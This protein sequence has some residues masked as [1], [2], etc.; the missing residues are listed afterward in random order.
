MDADSNPNMAPAL[1]VTST[2]RRL[3]LPTTLVSRRR[4]GSALT[5]T[6][7]DILDLHAAVAPDDVRLVHMGSP[8]HAEEGC[9]CS[10]HATVAALLRDA[11]DREDLFTVVD[12]EA[13]PEH[14]SRGTARSVDLLLLVTEPYYR[15]LES[16]R[17]LGDLAA[18]L[19]IPSVKVLVNKVRSPADADAVGEFCD[20]HGLERIAEVPWSEEAIN[21][22]RQGQPLLDAAPDSAAVA[23]VA[24]LADSLAAG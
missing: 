22:D 10:A 11:G 6:V 13:S 16:A 3:G 8:A 1:G 19:P 24:V 17:R 21:A 12:L 15:S 5:M 20:R 9:M 14:L 2:D 18:E 4:D 23:A 7:D